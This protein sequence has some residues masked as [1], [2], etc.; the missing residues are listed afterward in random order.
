[1]KTHDFIK[2]IVTTTTKNLIFYVIENP[3]TEINKL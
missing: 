2:E 1:M 3:H